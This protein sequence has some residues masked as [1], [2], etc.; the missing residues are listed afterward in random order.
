MN[1]QQRNAIASLSAAGVLWGLTV[2]LSKLSLAWLSPAWLTAGRFAI[3]ALILGW[4]ARRQLRTAVTP[5]V[6]T[7]G[8]VGFGGVVMLQNAGID[9][10]SV[11]AAAV[12]IG[13][14]PVL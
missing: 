1:C 2:P 9:R 12:V 10:T 4:T 5:R 11:S 3:A 14:V 7:A 13:T 6:I 8:A